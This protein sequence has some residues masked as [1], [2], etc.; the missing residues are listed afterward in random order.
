[1]IIAESNL[2][3]NT[4]ADANIRYVPKSLCSFNSPCAASLSKGNAS[5]P[6]TLP[7]KYAATAATTVK[8]SKKN[9]VT[10]MALFFTI[11]FTTSN[12]RMITGNAM[13]K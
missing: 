7:V 5:L 11:R 13:I 9:E 6:S 8:I 2:N 4:T 10:P 3:T 12:R 1:M